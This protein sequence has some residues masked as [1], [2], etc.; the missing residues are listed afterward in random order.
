[1]S[2][3]RKA[4]HKRGLSKQTRHWL[5]RASGWRL[6]SLLFQ[7]PTREAR[8]ELSRLTT[9]GPKKLAPL[10]REWAEAPNEEANSEFL[11]IFGPGG[12][13]AVESSYDPNALA[14]RGPLLADIAGFHEAFA[15]R[16]PQRPA[17]VPDHIAVE[18]DF[19]SYLAFKTAFALH[20]GQR[21]ESTITADAYER[22]LQD[23]LRTWVEAFRERVEQ[24]ASP[25]Y[26]RAALTVDQMARL[27]HAGPESN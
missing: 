8:R 24:S 16:P 26:A 11:A 9:E 21:E 27:A 2:T 15:Y 25:F 20:A 13:P 23:H 5:E 10:A 7:S 18:L 17:E 3:R 14:G 19:L 1:M 12:I 22:F 6:L 4:T